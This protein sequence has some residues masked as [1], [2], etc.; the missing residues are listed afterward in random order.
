[1]V[2]ACEPPLKRWLNPPMRAWT[3]DEG[4]VSSRKRAASRSRLADE[5]ERRR[6]RSM[7]PSR[8]RADACR[9][10]NMVSHLY[11]KS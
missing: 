11:Q 5:P 8:S 9:F 4:Q 10:V 7:T 3:S 1:M 6:S 2:P